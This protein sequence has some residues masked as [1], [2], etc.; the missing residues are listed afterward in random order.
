MNEKRDIIGM[1][2]T[3]AA[4]MELAEQKIDTPPTYEELVDR[5][6]LLTEENESLIA[7]NGCRQC[8][9]NHHA[10]ITQIKTQRDEAQKLAEEA[11]LRYNNTL[12]ATYC[13]YCGHEYPRG[14]PKSENALLTEHI[15]V[16]EKHPMRQ[17]EARIAKLEAE[18]EHGPKCNCQ[19][20]TDYHTR[21]AELEE[22]EKT[23]SVQRQHWVEVA[24]YASREADDLRA[25]LDAEVAKNAESV[26]EECIRAGIALWVAQHG[27]VCSACG[28]S[29]VDRDGVLL[30]IMECPAHPYSRREQ[31]LTDSEAARDA[32]QARLDALKPFIDAAKDLVMEGHSDRRWRRL[33]ARKD[34]FEEWEKE[35]AR[36]TLPKP[37]PARTARFIGDLQAAQEATRAHS[38][39]FGEPCRFTDTCHTATRGKCE[40]PLCSECNPKTR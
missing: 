12:Q 26:N 5:I 39:H 9:A 18:L 11:C 13:A 35:Q 36:A 7:E 22:S 16:C 3:E 23:L 14:T 24:E 29:F 27:Y 8:E 10:A 4:E 28:Q 15:A 40:G 21:I 38:I 6:A 20:V 37:D 2:A 25:R 30:H 34:D 32:L 33:A 19:I 31:A 1:V 17:A